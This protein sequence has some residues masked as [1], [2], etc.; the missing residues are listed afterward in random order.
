M[1]HV[2]ISAEIF[3]LWKIKVKLVWTESNIVSNNIIIIKYQ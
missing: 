1:I 2:S 3:S